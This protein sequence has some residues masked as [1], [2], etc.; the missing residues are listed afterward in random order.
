MGAQQRTSGG[1]SVS[2]FTEITFT[3]TTAEDE[4]NYFSGTVNSVLEPF[5][6][7]RIRLKEGQ[8][9]IVDGSIL[10]IISGIPVNELRKRLAEIG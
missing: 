7:D 6:G 3:S 1:N 10:P 4:Q 8:Y 9:R 5:A 2:K